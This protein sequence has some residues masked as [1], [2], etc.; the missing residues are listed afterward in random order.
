MIMPTPN[1]TS[2]NGLWRKQ[3][4]MTLTPPQ[5]ELPN[6]QTAPM[7]TLNRPGR[8]LLGWMSDHDGALALAGRNAALAATSEELR[9]RVIAARASV[10][11]RA[12]YQLPAEVVTTD[13]PD[14][15]LIEQRLRQAPDAVSFWAEGWRLAMVDLRHVCS[16]QPTVNT[17]DA[18]ER[19]AAVTDDDPITV[20]AVTLPASAPTELPVQFDPTRNT[21][22][23]NAPNPN[24]RIIGTFAPAAQ[25]G[26]AGI[27]LGFLIGIT[28][29]FLQVAL[30]HGRPVL[31]DGYHRAYGLL[32]RGIR[33][34]PAFVRDFGQSDLGVGPGLF[35]PDVYLST[36]PPLLT[37]FLD[38]DV[39]ASIGIPIS[40][41]MLVIQGLELTPL[42]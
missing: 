33:H 32:A 21:W 19:V 8:V 1:Q 11:S 18:L 39:A 13:H 4:E 5:D 41:K 6:H 30:H 36:Q 37:D 17:E 9:I 40:Q 26:G 31:R 3:T 42:A 34:V 35:P 2:R 20:A 14:L 38:D 29:S 22:L 23:V 12:P 25:P 16:L 27:A 28:A 24:L 10:A 15:V 7:G